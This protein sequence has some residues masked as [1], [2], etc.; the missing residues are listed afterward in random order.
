VVPSEAPGVP[1]VARRTVPTLP[2]GVPSA[3][4]VFGE[5]AAARLTASPRRN[6]RRMTLMLAAVAAT[7]S[8]GIG[9]P[10]ADA[11]GE[12]PGHHLGALTH[13]LEDDDR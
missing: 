12:A 6:R 7:V 11:Y 10:L 9:A 8:L 1:A 5:T 2:D 13:Y 3:A 4:P